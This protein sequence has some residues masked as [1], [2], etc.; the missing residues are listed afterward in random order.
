MDGWFD[1]LGRSLPAGWAIVATG[2]YANGLLCPGSDVDVVLI[3]PQR[4]ASRG[5]SRRSPSRCGTRCGTP[6]VK[7]S[8]AAHSVKSLAGAGVRRP[9]HGDGDPPPATRRRQRRRSDHRS[10][11]RVSTSGANG[12]RAGWPSC[13]PSRPIVGRSTGDVASLLEPDLKDGHGGLR[14][15]D[16]IRWALATDRAEI[17]AVAG[18]ADRRPRRAGRDAAGDALRAAPCDR[19]VDQRAC[20]CRI[21]TP[22]PRRWASPTPTC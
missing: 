9:G 5:G 19:Q 8:P 3:H 18:G 20:C 10:A 1:A 12:R 14:D 4:A 22:S 2:G 15:F 16:S 21:K 11:P 7:L 17:V 6:G 13:A